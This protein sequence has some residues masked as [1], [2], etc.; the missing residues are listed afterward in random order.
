MN[1]IVLQRGTALLTVLFILVLLSTLAV[2]TTED[3]NIAIRRAENQRDAE[4]SQQ[5]A[6]AGE[7]WVIKALE[8]D[9]DAAPA[10]VDSLADEW[11]LLQS[12][13]VKIEDGQMAVQ[14]QDE[15]GKFNL[16]NLLPSKIVEV[17]NLNNPTGTPLRVESPWYLF[18]ARLL[19]SV[20]LDAA[21]ADAVVDWIDPDDEITEQNG[22]EESVYLS[23]DPP[24]LTA[25]QPFSHIAELA[26]VEGFGKEEVEALAPHITALP[27]G[28][29]ANPEYVKVNVHTA[30]ATLLQSMDEQGA[31]SGVELEAW[32]NQ[33]P[34]PN[35]GLP[36]VHRL[37]FPSSGDY[38]AFEKIAALSSDYFSAHSCAKFGRVSY[39]Q[40]SLLKRD[41][42]KREVLVLSRQR[43]YNCGIDNSQTN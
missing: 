18:F 9:L 16:N 37:L 32:M 2:Y 39:A 20:N 34:N 27:I 26:L 41:S 42:T 8:R 7:K 29:P 38:D 40:Q 11:A 19:E 33:R 1:A 5:V 28:D 14:A 22:A 36:Q 21:L 6:L 10:D 35:V 43:R 3:E 23:A 12:Q 17:P 15:S 24:Y 31:N 4:Q 13:V 30:N 25:N